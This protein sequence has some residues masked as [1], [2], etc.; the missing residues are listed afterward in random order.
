MATTIKDYLIEKGMRRDLAL[1]L[2]EIC[3]AMH[4]RIFRFNKQGVDKH[5]VLIDL[6]K[7]RH[8][9]QRSPKSN[10]EML[11][12]VLDF[13]IL[14]VNFNERFRLLEH[15]GLLRLNYQS[16]EYEFTDFAKQFLQRPRI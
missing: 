7:Y 3:L 14:I 5:L 2:D 10:I 4:S 1:E 15:Y 6:G 13:G 16:G 8:L 9:E 11:R 12:V